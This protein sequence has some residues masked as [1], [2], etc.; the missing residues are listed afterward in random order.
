MGYTQDLLNY[1]FNNKILGVI[2]VILLFTCIGLI[3][4][5]L[6]IKPKDDNSNADEIKST[7]TK[8]WMWF[9]FVLF[10][11]IIFGVLLYKYSFD[12]KYYPNSMN[13]MRY[14]N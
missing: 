13:Y 7:K 2:V 4:A 12:T 6:K 9:G 11:F 1:H 8:L 5:A 14:R 3:I 10:L